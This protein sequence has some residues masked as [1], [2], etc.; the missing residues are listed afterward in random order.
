MEKESFEKFVSVGIAQ[1]LGNFNPSEIFRDHFEY[2]PDYYL[3]I[4]YPCQISS[5]KALESSAE[6]CLA[7]G[8]TFSKRLQVFSSFSKCQN[9]SQR[10]D[11]QASD[12]FVQCFHTDLQYVRCL[13]RGGKQ[14]K[15]TGR[16][17]LKIACA[18][19]GK[20][21]ELEE[22]RKTKSFPFGASFSRK[23]LVLNKTTEKLIK[24][25]LASAAFYVCI[26]NVV[27]TW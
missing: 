23:L 11:K 14:Q 7:Q 6:Q 16:A 5:L 9:W 2:F 4:I 19:N 3:K 8:Q 10:T 17:Q 18:R 25:R 13:T 1:H 24:Q 22:S 21:S 12:I 20:L 15:F 26:E 27:V